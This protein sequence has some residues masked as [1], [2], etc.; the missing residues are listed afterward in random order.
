M[1]KNVQQQGK[2]WSFLSFLLLVGC[3]GPGMRELKNWVS[4]IESRPGSGIEPPPTIEPYKPFTYSAMNLRDPFIA[5]KV[6]RRT[7]P[8]GPDLNRPREPLEFFSLEALTL[9]GTVTMN[10]ITWALVQDNKGIVHR[11]KPGNYMGT[12]YG[13]IEKIENN[14]IFL[15]ETVGDGSGGWKKISTVFKFEVLRSEK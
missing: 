10:D 5:P 3:F 12:N 6:V 4:E 2:L 11:V 13:K 9:V 7:G 14:E 1:L 15:T 8:G